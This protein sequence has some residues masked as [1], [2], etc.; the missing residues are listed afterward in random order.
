MYPFSSAATLAITRF[1]VS[2]IY[3]KLKAQTR[4]LEEAQAESAELRAKKQQEIEAA[5]KSAEKVV[6]H[7]KAE[8]SKVKDMLAKKNIDQAAQEKQVQLRLEELSASYG[9]RYP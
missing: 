5:V 7:A 2:E 1:Q 3:T 8:T 9:G 6:T 4:A